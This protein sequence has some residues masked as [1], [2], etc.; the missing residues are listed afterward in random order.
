MPPRPHPNPKPPLPA[1]T[2]SS[3]SADI[4]DGE[5]DDGENG[6][7]KTVMLSVAGIAGIAGLM[8]GGTF[9]YTKRRDERR[10]G[11]DRH[12]GDMDYEEMSEVELPDAS[13]PNLRVVSQDSLSSDSIG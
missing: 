10:D 4:D 9:L 1:N 5:I 7:V 13:D 8:L 2:P 11:I 3:G 12:H 6:T